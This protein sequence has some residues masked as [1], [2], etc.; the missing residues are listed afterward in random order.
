MGANQIR[1]LSENLFIKQCIVE[2]SVADGVYPS[3]SAY[4]DV[5]EY[6][7]FAFLI[8]VGDSDDT[9]VT[10]QVKQA[11]AAAGTGSK[12]V[13]GAAITGTS[14]AGSSSDDRWAMI[15]VDNER[16]DIAN[17]FDHV[18][19]DVAATGGSA[20]ELVVFFFGIEPR[21]KPPTFGSDKAEIVYVD[22]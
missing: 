10:A 7:R 8:A 13:T 19:L 12:D 3:S 16:L 18:A 20:T 21:V 2:G 11:T 15:E 1:R 4:I 14:L 5:S 6:S 17:D 22:G 9:A